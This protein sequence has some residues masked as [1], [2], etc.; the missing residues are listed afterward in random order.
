MRNSIERIIDMAG[1]LG[2]NVAKRKAL[3]IIFQRNVVEISQA[4]E[5]PE[6]SQPN[7]LTLKNSFPDTNT[8]LNNIDEEIVNILDPNE[9]LAELNLR[10]ESVK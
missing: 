8:N 1:I 7:F 2:R 5:D 6:T 9:V 4:L 10:L 3:R